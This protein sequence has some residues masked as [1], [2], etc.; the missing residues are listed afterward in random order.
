MRRKYKAFSHFAF[1][2]LMAIRKEQSTSLLQ[3]TLES[4]KFGGQRRIHPTG[5]CSALTLREGGKV[6]SK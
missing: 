1:E 4:R 6:K 3:K 5:G 2:P